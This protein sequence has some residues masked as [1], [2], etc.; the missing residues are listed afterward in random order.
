MTDKHCGLRPI[1]ATTV[2]QMVFKVGSLAPPDQWELLPCMLHARKPVTNIVNY[3]MFLG[4]TGL[5]LQNNIKPL[6]KIKKN[7]K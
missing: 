2:F 1:W 7:K 6:E 4:N 3:F 5:V